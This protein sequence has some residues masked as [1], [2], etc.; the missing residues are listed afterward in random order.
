MFVS[1]VLLA[2][3]ATAWGS[4]KAR[5]DYRECGKLTPFGLISLLSMYFMVHLVLGYAMTYGTPRTPL[6][7]TGVALAVLGL[8]LCFA[9]MV[10]FR[11]ARK[12]FG[13]DA[14]MLTV[15]GPYRWSRNPQ[16]IGWGMFFFGLAFYG[17][18]IWCIIPL[19]LFA[20]VTHLL[21]AGEEEHLLRQFGDDYRAYCH[22]TPRY[23][24]R[25]D[26]AS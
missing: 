15:G 18:T 6:E 10:A 23:V 20:V 11:S 3:A 16:Y 7:I 19:L 26:A 8:T 22:R 24:G 1:L 25:P 14:G 12:T 21:I 4:W 5:R 17:W 9:A 2:F 13:L